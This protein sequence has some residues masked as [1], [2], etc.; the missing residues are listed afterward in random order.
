MATGS[1]K[2]YSSAAYKASDVVQAGPMTLQLASGFNPQTVDLFLLF[3]N[4]VAVPAA[5]AVPFYPIRVPAGGSY[6]WGSDE[7][8]AQASQEGAPFTTGCCYA[9]STTGNIY[10]VTA[11]GFWVDVYGR[12]R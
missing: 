8:A 7:L 2:K 4:L 6:S 5:G 3:F 10:T 12:L 9:V 1:P 11:L